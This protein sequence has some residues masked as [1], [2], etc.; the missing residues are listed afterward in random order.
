MSARPSA[1]TRSPAF[2]PRTRWS[3][4]VCGLGDEPVPRRLGE[5]FD[6]HPL[7][8]EDVVNVPQRPKAEAYEQQHLVITRMAKAT[9]GSLDV[10]QVSLFIGS[11]H[12]LTIQEREGDVFDPVR[13]RIRAG[14]G[15]IRRSR[16]VLPRICGTAWT[17]RSRVSP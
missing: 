2:S 3:G 6:I 5:I 9:G 10:E 12:L 15:L 8:L 4:D 14:K 16:P 1:W 17:T 13:V 7:A 11:H